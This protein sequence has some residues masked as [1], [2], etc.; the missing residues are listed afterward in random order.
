MTTSTTESGAAQKVEQAKQGVGE[1]AGTAAQET[2]HVAQEA[3]HEIREL[4]ETLKEQVA[5][6]SQAGMDRLVSTLGELADEL[7][8]MARGER[9]GEGMAG[10]LVRQASTRTRDVADSLRDRTPGD[11]LHDV[12]SFARRR[13]GTFLLAAA[14]GGVLVGRMTRGAASAASQPQD[15]T[16]ARQVDLRDGST[17]GAGAQWGAGPMGGE[18]LGTGLGAQ[19]P[20]HRS[21]RTGA[22]QGLGAEQDM[23]MEQ[24]EPVIISALNH[25]TSADDM[26]G[27]TAEMPDLDPAVDE[28][29]YGR[30]S[31]P[32]VQP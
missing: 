25:P 14:V 18:A 3:G 7:G 32:A 24:D 27:G 1:V 23:G 20:E 16:A 4:T 5:E 9:P 21:M 6:Q 8:A 12:E 28:S 26:P 30:S 10:D 13:P 2:R 17:Y 22:G 29:T 15:G 11:L 31:G 19:S